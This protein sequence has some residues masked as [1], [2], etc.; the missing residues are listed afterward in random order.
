MMAFRAIGPVAFCLAALGSAGAHAATRSDPVKVQGGV[1]VG[2][3]AGALNTYLGIPFA[4]PPVGDLRW[5]APQAVVPWQGVREARSFSAA[6]AQTAVWVTHP[7]SEDCLY[8]NVW[9]PQS[10]KKLP[11]IV[12]IH[13][14]GYYGGTAASDGFH[15]ANLARR[16]AVVVSVNYRLGIFGF[17][18]HPELTA[19][20]SDHASGNQGILDQIAALRWVRNNIAAFGGDPAR[21]AIAGESAGGSSVGVLVAS[22]LAKGLFQRA[23]AES[24]NYSVPINGDETQQFDRQTAESEGREF[25]TALGARNLA[26]LRAMSVDALHK[27][28]WTPRTIVEGHLLREDLGTTY[29]HHRQNDVPLLVGWN[30]EEGKDLAPEI[31]G[32]GEFTAAKHREHVDKLMLGHTPSAALLA[33]YPGVTDAG[34]RASILQLTN[35]WWG[36]RMVHWAALQTKYGRS[37]AYAYFF[38]HRPAAPL[39]PCGYGCGAGHGA[40]IAYVF[41]NLDRDTRPWSAS[42][43]QLAARLATTWINFARSGSPLGKSLPAWPRYDG[44]AASVARI[45]DEA[46]L[47]EFKLPDFSV[48]PQHVE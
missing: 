6:C 37:P 40:E 5:R 10:A 15:G 22:P 43:R 20:S 12:W 13:G 33:A 41:D 16:G 39:T 17:F 38:A 11:V 8:L 46:E 18:A 9:A 30:A 7:K 44:S 3:H 31:L 27:R 2:E 32:T 42:D 29:R 23:I 45:G 25:A 48:F 35:D 28:A 4:A 24:G 36:W 34:A 47:K 21:V 14:G 26:D 19:Q 1:I